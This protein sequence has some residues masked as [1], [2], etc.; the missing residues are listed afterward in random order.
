MKILVLKNK[1]NPAVFVE[2]DS[3]EII[4][5]LEES[6]FKAV[7]GPYPEFAL[8]IA[9]DLLSG[10]QDYEI[11]DIKKAPEVNLNGYL[12]ISFINDYFI[13][14]IRNQ[15]L[16]YFQHLHKPGSK[17]YS[18]PKQFFSDV[19]KLIESGMKVGW[20]QGKWKCGTDGIDLNRCILE[21]TSLRCPLKFYDSPQLCQL[22]SILGY[23]PAAT[24]MG[25]KLPIHAV[26]KLKEDKIDVLV[27]GNVIV[28]KD[29][30][31][32]RKVLK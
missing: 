28:S 19:A 10:E 30:K 31:K 29:E 3:E 20:F 11:H 18:S 27:M 8:Q 13:G 23:F 12:G 16:F 21:K 4:Y 15:R 1:E 25:I 14:L 2:S 17:V 32:L 9:K 7:E 6:K 26:N 5:V 22:S 24:D